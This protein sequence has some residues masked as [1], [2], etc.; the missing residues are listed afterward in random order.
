M[1]NSP[2]PIAVARQNQKQTPKTVVFSF[3]VLWF[4]WQLL[5]LF[6]ETLGTFPVNDAVHVFLE[7]V[8]CCQNYY[9]NIQGG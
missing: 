4:K 2:L 6:K 5:S 1:Q 7:N 9:K 3:S 8:S